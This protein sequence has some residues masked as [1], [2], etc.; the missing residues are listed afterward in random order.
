M[1]AG[2]EEM[3]NPRGTGTST[4]NAGNGYARISFVEE[5]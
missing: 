2:N 1:K 5:K 3:P 4:G